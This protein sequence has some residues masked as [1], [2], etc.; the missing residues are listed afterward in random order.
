MDSRKTRHLV[1][2]KQNV[3]YIGNAARDASFFYFMKAREVMKDVF[4]INIQI[5]EW[6]KHL[7]YRDEGKS[8]WSISFVLG[9]TQNVFCFFC[10]F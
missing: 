4:F 6:K 3:V 10:F 5:R 9:V 8:L 7:G 2:K 1:T